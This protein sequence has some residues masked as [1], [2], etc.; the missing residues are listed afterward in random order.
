ML[1]EI[2]GHGSSYDHSRGRD[3]DKSIE[4][5]A[6]AMRLALSDARMTGDQIDCLSMSA[7]G[8]V[9][10]DRRE[11]RAVVVSLDG[12]SKKIPVT[13]IKSMLGETLG[14]SGALQTVAMVEAMRDGVIPGISQLEETEKT[15]RSK[16]QAAKAG[17]SIFRAASSTRSALTGIA[18]R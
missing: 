12:R 11:A 18:V 6:R 14:A 13:A 2:K 16:W 7:N 5:I 17:N 10:M 8:S 1:A 4:A 15:F 9:R 3:D